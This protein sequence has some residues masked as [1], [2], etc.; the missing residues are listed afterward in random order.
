M[1]ISDIKNFIQGNY[2]YFTQNSTHIN[3]QAS[4]RQFMCSS[5]LSNGSCLSC[6]CKTPNMFYSPNKSDSLLRWGPMLDSESWEEFKKSS[7]YFNIMEAMNNPL[8]EDEKTLDRYLSTYFKLSEFDCR[9][10]P[11]SGAKFMDLRFL[12]R[13]AHS[14]HISGIPFI[15]TS[16]YR[17]KEY[18][19]KLIQDGLRASKNSP[20]LR[21]YAADI[22]CTDSHQ[23]SKII[24]SLITSG[25]NRIGIGKSFIHVDSDPNLQSNLIWTYY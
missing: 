16:G 8:P 14:R 7:T 9:S 21:G 1:D 22:S 23:R 13:L 24:N 18:N 19:E 10:T 4:M 12:R 6:G 11:G 15:I 2:N 25:F 3:E 20:H 17:T 5:C